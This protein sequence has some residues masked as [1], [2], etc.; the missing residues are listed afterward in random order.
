VM[1]EWIYKPNPDWNISIGAHVVE[2]S[3]SKEY[4]IHGRSV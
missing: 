1:R 4:Q 2:G 3:R